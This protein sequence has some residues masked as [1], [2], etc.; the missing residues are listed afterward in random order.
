ML[1]SGG[2]TYVPT[3]LLQSVKRKFG[4]ISSKPVEISEKLYMGN[5]CQVLEFVENINASC[6]C[7]TPGC[8]GSL[9]PHRFI[10]KGLGGAIKVFFVCNGCWV[11]TASF[12]SSLNYEGP[13]SACV[14]G[15]ALQ[16][17]FFIS[18]RTYADY[19][20]A[21]NMCLGMSGV[22]P[23]TF[24]QTI[25]YVYEPVLDIL[26]EQCSDAIADM[27]ATGDKELGSFARAVTTGDGVWHTR[28]FSKNCTFTVRNFMNNS[29]LYYVHL[30][31]KGRDKVVPGELYQD[32]SHSAEGIGADIAFKHARADGMDIEV[33]WQDGD[34]SSGK[35]FHK[36][37]PDEQRS[38]V[39]QC[40]GHV[41]K[42]FQQQLQRAQKCKSVAPSMQK[43]FEKRSIETK[44]KNCCCTRNHKQ[45]C[46]CLTP[47]FVKKARINFHSSLVNA[48][49]SPEAFSRIMKDVGSYHC[50]DVHEW[51]NGGHCSFHK[52]RLCT[53]EKCGDGEVLCEGKPY[54]TKVPL[55]CGY[56]QLEFELECHKRAD[57]AEALIHPVLGKG[58][59][60]LPESSHSILITFRTKDVALGR[61]HY[62]ISTNL[63]LLQANL[64]Y[65][66]RK[67]GPA[68]HWILDLFWR[69]KL[70]VTTEMENT[71]RMENER[72]MAKLEAIK[73]DDSKK[74]RRRFKNERDADQQR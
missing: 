46:G 50:C 64:S 27:K 33:H 53:C 55:T 35:S 10:S 34:S 32:T 45:A 28:K 11:R 54:H 44:H 6:R 1:S 71:L 60:N 23:T 49:T 37:Y 12:N 19:N 18:G 74:Q 51:E 26:E 42:N 52:L 31:M 15:F 20:R 67:R 62:I 36:H 30:C 3:T 7:A 25:K 8:K 38:R 73:Q 72:R 68:Y 16:V 47:A 58:H 13:S 39:M 63:G 41:A 70:P 17:A 29:L 57:M 48:G 61:L 24:Y 2:S 9:M 22:S 21:V 5:A 66:H 65:M 69:L 43:Q 40:G 14:V 4:S 56:H 59:T